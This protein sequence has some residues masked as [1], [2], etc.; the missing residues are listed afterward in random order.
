[1]R[2]SRVGP[3]LDIQICFVHA[4]SQYKCRG[5]HVQL[6]SNRLSL[7]SIQLEN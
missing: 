6:Y 1:M 3:E 4:S 7:A 2:I 5:D